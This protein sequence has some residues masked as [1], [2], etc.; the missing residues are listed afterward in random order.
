MKLSLIAACCAAVFPGVAF[1]AAI[2][3]PACA[4]HLAEPPV[5]GVLTQQQIDTNNSCILT[6]QQ[7]AAVA[8]TAA[9]I[10]DNNRRASGKPDRADNALRGYSSATPPVMMGA[11]PVITTPP[12]DA[13]PAVPHSEPTTPSTT[14]STPAASASPPVVDGI[15]WDGAT[16]SAIIRFPDGSSM[17][18]RRGTTLPDGATVAIVSRAGVYVDNSGTIRPLRTAGGDIPAPGTTPATTLPATGTEPVTPPSATATR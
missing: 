6:L 18:V 3:L 11:P 9:R 1:A 2:P 8:E 15:M 10:E 16:Y 4:L 5:G 13:K 12:Q 17:E 7:D 14:A